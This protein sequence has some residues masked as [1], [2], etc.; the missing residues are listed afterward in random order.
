MPEVLKKAQKRRFWGFV[1]LKED[2]REVTSLSTSENHVIIHLPHLESL[3]HAHNHPVSERGST[4]VC[5]TVRTTPAYSI[6]CQMRSCFF[7]PFISRLHLVPGGTRSS[8]DGR[9]IGLKEEDKRTGLV[10]FTW[11]RLKIL[12]WDSASL[13]SFIDVGKEENSNKQWI[14]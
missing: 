8:L 5:Y 3:W 12:W 10:I 2:L 9:G 1:S 11:T 6:I 7:F 13:S 14:R 4:C